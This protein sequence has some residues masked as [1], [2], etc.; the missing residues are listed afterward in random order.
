M[1]VVAVNP[2]AHLARILK[3]KPMDGIV[4]GCMYYDPLVRDQSSHNAV[5]SMPM[6]FLL[7]ALSFYRDLVL[8]DSLATW[9]APTNARQLLRIGQQG[10]FGFV[11]HTEDALQG[12]DVTATVVVMCGDDETAHGDKTT[13]KEKKDEEA[14]NAMETNKSEVVVLN[15]T[16]LQDLMDTKMEEDNQEKA[17][18][19]NGIQISEMN[20]EKDANDE[21]V[22]EEKRIG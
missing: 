1:S 19:S 17:E 18:S 15:D 7:N 21:C 13:T 10:P 5:Y 4:Y 20:V 16:K 8:D 2:Y 12:D 9:K 14:N 11:Y 3:Y 22:L 6:V